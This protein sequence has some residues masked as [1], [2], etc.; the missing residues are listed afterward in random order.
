MKKIAIAL[1][2]AAAVLAGC[3]EK[4]SEEEKTAQ[5]TVEQVSFELLPYAVITEEKATKAGTRTIT[6]AVV[7]LNEP[8]QTVNST[9][10]AATCMGAAKYF[11]EHNL[12]DIASVQLIDRVIGIKAAQIAVARCNYATDG[13]GFNGSQKWTWDDVM[14]ADR[15]TTKDEQEIV[16]LWA[17]LRNQ[18]LKADGTTD[19]PA[20]VKAIATKLNKKPEEIVTPLIALGAV[21][22]VDA[23]AS[24]VK[25]H[26]PTE[27]KYD[28]SIDK[29]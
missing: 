20:L 4:T 29:K 12:T 13:K 18:H 16:R 2:L 22:N 6:Y 11:A 7:G 23:I 5:K 14:A 28:I 26:K 19:E 21:A 9:N 17:G 1:A 15:T 10:L 25:A 3:V 8:A 27:I 24:A